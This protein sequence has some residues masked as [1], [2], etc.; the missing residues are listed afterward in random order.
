VP[1]ELAQRAQRAGPAGAV[2]DEAVLALE[3]AQRLLR[4][5]AED[6]VGPAGVEAQ[7]QQALLQ[8]SD[9]V[10]HER[11]GGQREQPVAELPA[12]G[13]QRAVGLRAHDPVHG[14]PAALLELAQRPI[15][16]LVEDVVGGDL[17]EQVEAVQQRLHVG[18]GGTP[19]AEAEQLHEGTSRRDGVERSHTSGVSRRRDYPA[20]C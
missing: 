20:P 2:R 18:D 15:G 8:G 17:G 14:E 11:P 1:P 10:A 13:R 7:L 6:A 3:P 16:R 4:T 19:V 5:G 12:G 9:V